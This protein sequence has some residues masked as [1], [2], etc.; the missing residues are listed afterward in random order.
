MSTQGLIVRDDLTQALVDPTTGITK[1]VERA[2]FGTVFTELGGMA[3][4]DVD[5]ENVDTRRIASICHLIR[6]RIEDGLREQSR[7]TIEFIVEVLGARLVS[8][9]GRAAQ[10]R[11]KRLESKRRR[12]PWYRLY[13][14][15]RK[16]T[17]EEHELD[18]Q[19]H[20]IEA[21]VE[22]VR[23]ALKE[24]FWL[25]GEAP[26]ELLL[27]RRLKQPLKAMRWGLESTYVDSVLNRRNQLKSHIMILETLTSTA[28]STPQIQAIR[29]IIEMAKAKPKHY[30]AGVMHYRGMSE[31]IIALLREIE[32]AEA[33]YEYQRMSE[34][35]TH[36]E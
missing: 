3:P 30:Q 36:T 19:Q 28:K 14:P 4:Q 29:S 1:E 23:Q 16:A 5:P 35:F 17:R 21:S 8:I 9:L 22:T 24:S 32:Q 12:T 27:M 33:G 7:P 26:E 2:L 18:N 6:K 15:D 34:F 25:D 20:Q 13:R 11:R 10:E 31:I